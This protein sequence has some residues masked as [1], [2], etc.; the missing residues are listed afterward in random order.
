MI[1]QACAQ[2]ETITV[3]MDSYYEERSESWKESE[4][5]ENFSERLESM[6]EILSL[7]QG[8]T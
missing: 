1:R 6:E 3:E 7:I 5:G 4:R 2:L 8:L